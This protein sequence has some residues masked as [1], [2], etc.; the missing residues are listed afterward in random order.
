MANNT[1][2]R[3]MGDTKSAQG[4]QNGMSLIVGIVIILI[5]A[6]FLSAI[7]ANSDMAN[8]IPRQTVPILVFLGGII[9]AGSGKAAQGLGLM[10]LG[11]IFILRNMGVFDTATF[12][13]AWFGILV[14]VGLLFVLMAQVK[15]KDKL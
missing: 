12:D 7:L 6:G 3:N 11:F 8:L 15:P 10:A 13:T 1:V 5:G 2:Q 14:L 9:M 4:W